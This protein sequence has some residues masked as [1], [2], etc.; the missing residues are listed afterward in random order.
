LTSLWNIL[1]DSNKYMNIIDFY[2]LNNQPI[3]IT[4]RNQRNCKQYI[5]PTLEDAHM[6]RRPRRNDLNQIL[7]FSLSHRRNQSFK[8]WY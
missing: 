5:P 8:I 6:G 2:Q 1:S 4:E 3:I 7:Q